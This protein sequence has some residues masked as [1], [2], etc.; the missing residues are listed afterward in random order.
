MLRSFHLHPKSLSRLA[1]TEL[2]ERFSF[3]GLNAFLI[4][5]M[6]KILHIPDTKALVVFATYIAYVYTLIS[7]GGVLADRLFGYYKTVF[8][9]GVFILCGNI[10]IAAS[11]Y[12]IDLFYLGLGFIATGT[13]LFRPNIA[14]MVGKLYSRDQDTIRV[15]GFNIFYLSMNIA[16]FIAPIVLGFAIQSTTYYV[17]FL[18]LALAILFGL[19]IFY[20]GY[21][22][23]N[24]DIKIHVP[25]M[26]ITK[27]FG[28]S[29]LIWGGILL[30]LIALLFG[31]LIAKPSSALIVISA[32]ATG[33]LIY[34]AVLWKTLKPKERKSLLVIFGFAIFSIIFWTIS[35][36]IIMTLPLCIDKF[37]NRN[38]LG[39]L[40]P[41]S[42]L[43]GIYGLLLI[44]CAPLVAAF[45]FWIDKSKNKPNYVNKFILGFIFL[46]VTSTFIIWGVNH[47]ISGLMLGMI[48]V[49]I[50]YLFLV[51]GELCISPNGLSLVTLY[52]PNNLSGTMVSFWYIINA[53]AGLIASIIP[54]LF[55]IV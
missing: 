49:F 53:F 51:L 21:N 18:T 39:F 22:K 54:H 31:F 1:F 34:I 2:F 43:T 5:F 6:T 41:S 46:G 12:S 17:G 36:Q 16:S 11:I 55:G 3:Y 23:Y 37:V 32:C 26:A 48:W 52:T 50:C 30:V 15:Q 38:I 7:L 19:I 24:L 25:D 27:Y 45:W 42:S 20:R 44:V 13:G 47:A 40:I 14:T 10:I 9:G 4:I 8:I 28:I 29:T 33:L 35:N